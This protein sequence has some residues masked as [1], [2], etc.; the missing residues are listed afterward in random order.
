MEL[1]EPKTEPLKET[2]IGWSEGQLGQL[3]LCEEGKTRGHL[4]GGGA[5][6]G[7]GDRGTWC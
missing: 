6:R 3:G 5:G 2:S 7:P 1:P 4:R